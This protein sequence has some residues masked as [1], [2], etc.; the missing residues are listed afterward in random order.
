[1]EHAIFEVGLALSLVAVAAALSDRLR[2]SVVPLLILVGIVVGPH[3]PVFGFVDLRFIRTAPLIDFMGRVGILFLLFYL[4][5]EFSIERLIKAG[6]TVTKAGIIYMSINFPLGILIGRA[7]GWPMKETLVVAG[8]TAISSSAIVAKLVAELKRT[9][10]PETGLLLGIMLFQD[11]FVALYLALISGWVFGADGGNVGLV[12]GIA[13]AFVFGF[14]I[15]GRAAVPWLNRLFAIASDEVFVLVGSA[16]L[17][18]VSGLSA[19]FQVAEAT[20]ALLLGLALAE[21]DHRVRLERLFAP[22]RDFFG[23]MF[24]F[25]FGL[26]IDPFAMGGAVWIGLAAVAIT[27]LGNLAAG[28]LV[29]RTGGL[30][31][32]ASTYLGLA[33][34]PRGE[35]SIVL[36]NLAATGGLL[37][38]LGT[39]ATFYVLVLSVLGSLVTKEARH[40]H[41]VL[42]R[43]VRW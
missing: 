14:I 29:G 1:M 34:T 26:S 4:G 32:K 19:E 7:A 9:V 23:A 15:V 8:M 13:V 27:L 3:A 41:K 31:A 24:F 2:F 43:V 6:W 21:T 12:L 39:F 16:G 33:L 35:F 20:G 42:G 11:I 37:P 22:F 40:I 28:L 38:A 5:L 36:A 10:H 25:S 17:L 18:L 30:T